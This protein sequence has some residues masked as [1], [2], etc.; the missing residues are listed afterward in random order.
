MLLASIRCSLMAHAGSLFSTLIIMM[1]VLSRQRS[2]SGKLMLCEKCV[3]SW[4]SIRLWKDL[5]RVKVHM[6]GYSSVNQF[7]LPRLVNS[8]SLC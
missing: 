7:R 1:R 2:G 5:G 3:L 4:V 6:C 8:V